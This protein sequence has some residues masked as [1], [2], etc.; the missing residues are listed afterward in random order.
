M[1]LIE[2]TVGIDWYNQNLLRKYPLTDDSTT[3]D[4]STSI[5]LPDDFIVDFSLSIAN[6][7]SYDPAKFYISGVSIFGPGVVLTISYDAGTV[8]GSVSI[9]KAQH[10]VYQSYLFVGTG[11]FSD[12]FGVI[13]IGSL[14]TLSTI[15]GSYTFALTDA[16]FVPTTIKPDVKGITSLTVDN[17]GGEVFGPLTGDV[18]LT[19]GTNIHLEV[20]GQTVTINAVSGANLN[21]SCDCEGSDDITLGDPIRTINGIPPVNGDMTVNGTGCLSVNSLTNGLELEDTC[22]DPCCDSRELE[23]I[24]AK[25]N[26]LN[27]DIRTQLFL[28]QRLET[29]LTQ[30]D[31]LADAIAATGF[32]L[33]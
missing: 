5:R 19:A 29:N 7:Q 28:M 1:P 2:S 20:S 15:A 6:F 22:A 16:R 8:V 21:Q 13:T 26:Q 32:I 4:S 30:L 25:I 18:I 9:S 12:V 14:D 17:T 33:S 10:T 11:S 24:Q 23:E 31:S 27:I 3:Q